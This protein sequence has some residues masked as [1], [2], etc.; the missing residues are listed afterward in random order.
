LID[1]PIAL[2]PESPALPEL[3]SADDERGNKNEPD[4]LYYH[5]NTRFAVVSSNR[6]SIGMAPTPHCDPRRL[7]SL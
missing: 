3:A 6:C 4:D 1:D 5:F 2:N 7:A